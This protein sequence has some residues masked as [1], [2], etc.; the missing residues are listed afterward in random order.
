M[1]WLTGRCRDPLRGRFTDGKCVFAD[2]CASVPCQAWC[3]SESLT[4]ASD[5]LCTWTGTKCVQRA[6]AS[7]V[8]APTPV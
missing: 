7:P 2:T 6:T 3:E 4:S 1:V 5:K 8:A